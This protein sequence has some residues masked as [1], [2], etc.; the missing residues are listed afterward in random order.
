[1]SDAMNLYDGLLRQPGA[2]VD[3]L[4]QPGGLEAWGPPLLGAMAASAGLF[5]AVVGA[6]HGG[7]QVAYAAIKAP[8]LF[9]LP[10]VVAL[11]AVQ[12]LW[13]LMGT[14][15]RWRRL[16]AAGLVGM[17]R[18]ALL[19]A[20]LGPPLWLLY[21][22]GFDY[23]ASVLVFAGTLALAG[24][25]GLRT[26]LEALPAPP[27]GGRIVMGAA[28]VVLATS[29]AQTGWLLRP[30]VARPTAQVT[31]LR[32]LEEDILSALGATTRS[33]RGDYRGWEAESSGFL[34]RKP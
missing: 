22:T 11:P 32:P 4:D 25:P 16:S 9:L 33:A 31:L 1:M 17:A 8:F 34:G 27:T 24:L 28:M 19:A 12:A 21:S 7:A 10:T 2:L 6:H 3:A 14:E 20:A 15:V 26:A 30:F 29:F 23:H 18:S 5:G 13:G